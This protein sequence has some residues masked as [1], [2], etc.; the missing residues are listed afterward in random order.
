MLG[1]NGRSHG[2]GRRIH[3]WLMKHGYESLALGIPD[4]MSP[5]VAFLRSRVIDQ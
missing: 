5:C 4:R 3:W 1:N 2:L